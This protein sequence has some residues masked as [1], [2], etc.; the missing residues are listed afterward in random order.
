M[1]GLSHNQLTTI[2]SET[3]NDLTSLVKIQLEYN[4]LTKISEGTFRPEITFLDNN[5]IEGKRNQYN[6]EILNKLNPEYI[7]ENG[8][9]S[10]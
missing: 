3:F 7:V 6:E 5:F 9:N 10:V 8:I 4:L 2:P 1:L